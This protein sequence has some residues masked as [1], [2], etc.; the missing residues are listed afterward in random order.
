MKPYYQR[1][2]ITIYNNDCLCVL[3]SIKIEGRVLLLTDPPYG[4]GENSIKQ[5]ARQCR[6]RGNS[7]A[8]ADQRDYGEFHWDAKLERRHIDKLISCSDAQIIWG[9]NYYANWL[10]AS[11]CWLV[12][13]KDNGDNDFAD[14]E[15]AWT[16]FPSAVRIFKW[17]WNGM[18]QGDMKHK[19]ERVHPTQ[20]PLP[21]MKWCIEKY[22]KDFD[23]IL[24]PFGGSMTTLVAAKLL[25]KRAIAIELDEN[26]CRLGASRLNQETLGI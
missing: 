5:T 24:D 18:L 22:G 3:D 9:G 15:L 10:P 12:W 20:K 19:E 4:I 8:L 17:R 25:G 1:G 21:L 11:S 14:C 23:V 2:N 26:Y 7:K 16:S 6:G 13:D